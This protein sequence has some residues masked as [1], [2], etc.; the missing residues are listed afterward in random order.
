MYHPLASKQDPPPLTKSGFANDNSS[1]EAQTSVN[2]VAGVSG[3]ILSHVSPPAV[4]EVSHVHHH[5]TDEDEM[6]NSEEIQQL[7][8]EHEKKLLRA[9]KVFHTRMESLQRSLEEKEA[10]H[11]KTLEKHE[12]ERAALEK[13]LKMAEEEQQKRLKQLKE[14]FVLQREMAKQS[15]KSSTIISQSVAPNQ[16]SSLEGEE[17]TSALEARLSNFDLISLSDKNNNING[18]TP[19]ATIKAPSPP[20]CEEEIF[21]NR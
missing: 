11:L 15:K 1:M 13:R 17:A 7:K 2:P 19:D 5:D 21:P 6:S 9:Q 14:E 20:V 8:I 4:N 10:Q 16:L 18:D 12:R 3:Q